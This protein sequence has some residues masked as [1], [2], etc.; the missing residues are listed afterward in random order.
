MLQRLAWLSYKRPYLWAFVLGAIYPLGLAPLAWWPLLFVSIAGLNFLFLR[1]QSERLATIAYCYGLG[2]FAVGASWVHV[3]I[4][5]FG[6]A[7]LLMSVFLTALFVA[8][9]AVFKL[10]IGLGLRWLFQRYGVVAIQYGFPLLWLAM[11]GALANFFTGF[12]WLFAG[13][14]LV[15]SPFAEVIAWV[16]VYGASF[17]VALVASQMAWIVYV[18]VK[19]R[20][21]F[22]YLTLPLVGLILPI[23]AILILVNTFRP[24]E[25]PGQLKSFVLVQ[26]NIPQQD[27]WKRELL[28][29]H[30]QLY[31]DLT[32]EHLGSDFVIWP[33]AA[34]P[35]L[36]HRV[37]NWLDQWDRLARERGSQMILG[38]P[39]YQ[40]ETRKI[41]A[42][43][44]TLGDTQQRYDKQHL[45]P[46][47]EFVPFESWLR[48]L[49]EFFNL[50]MSAMAPGA[51]NQVAFEFDD[52]R[53]LPAICYEI[54]YSEVFFDFLKSDKNQK[55]SFILTVSNDAWFG[56]S[57]GPHQ[58][59]QIAQSRALEFGM[60]VIRATNNGITAII[61]LHGQRIAQ[62]KQFQRGVL[63][64]QIELSNRLTF[65]L[66]MPLI[67]VS[68]F[69][70]FG[71][72]CYVAFFQNS[73][74]NKALNEV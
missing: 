64:D 3:S 19:S 46:F 28:G 73:L 23:V 57:W 56:R 53:V 69:V 31:Q 50:P 4:H 72:L 44:I 9:L 70:F 15:D 7:P 74:K 38:I 34:V 10:F 11:D 48:G 5:Q 62:I 65:Y 26:P 18:L 27:K 8:F 47:G 14:G 36:K 58:H 54:A 21:S 45:V 39:I 12:P 35:E 25:T 51:K 16:G 2:F 24:S 52:T 20:P 6:N 67:M 42:S 59:L 66:K 13:Y 30:L 61:N 55:D 1:Y 60:P 37:S 22:R 63:N 33:E 68:V 32:L 40:P 49:I 17:W 71:M 29:Q 41:Y 43:L